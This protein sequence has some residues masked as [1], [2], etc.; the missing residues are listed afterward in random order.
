MPIKKLTLYIVLYLI[1]PAIVTIFFLQREYRETN[2]NVDNETEK[3]VCYLTFDDGPSH[4]TEK[5]L[6]ILK[7]YNIKATFFLIGSEIEQEERK[8]LER[9]K[10]EG[11][12]IGLHSTAHDFNKVYQGAETCV[13]EYLTEYELLKNEYGIDTHLFRFPG[14]S[15]CTYMNGQRETYIRLM[16]KNGFLCYDWHVSGEDAVGNPTIYSVQKNVMENVSDFKCPIILLHDSRVSQ[17]TVDAL[18][19]IIESLQEKHYTFHTLEE[20]EEYIFRWK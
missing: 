12:A 2:A 19:G 15:A 14:G 16:Q 4:N 9:M 1:L 7:K 13:E 11:H 8:I 17:V 18:P 10:S 6:D 20:R 3:K 5:V